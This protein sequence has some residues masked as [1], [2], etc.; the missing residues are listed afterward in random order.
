MLADLQQLYTLPLTT[1]APLIVVLLLVLGSIL[2]TAYVLITDAIQ[3]RADKAA[4]R[5]AR[6]RKRRMSR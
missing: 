1:L 5:E 4:R 6:D 3:R 2:V